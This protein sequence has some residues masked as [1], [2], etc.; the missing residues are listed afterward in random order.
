MKKDSI[1]ET[2]QWINII[3]VIKLI[4]KF[5]LPEFLLVKTKNIPNSNINNFTN[6]ATNI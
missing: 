5:L 1:R 4:N 6:V 3:T 2:K